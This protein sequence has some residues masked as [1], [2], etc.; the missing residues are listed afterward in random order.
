MFG[1]RG[2]IEHSV[3][4]REFDT[5]AEWLRQFY[6]DENSLKKIHTKGDQANP[7]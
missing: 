6:I 7:L 3:A 2:E 1:L 5:Y 4:Q